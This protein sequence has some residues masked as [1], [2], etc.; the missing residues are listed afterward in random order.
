[1]L[2]A[3]GVLVICYVHAKSL[4]MSNSLKPHGL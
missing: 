1:M 4:V 3:L 2:G